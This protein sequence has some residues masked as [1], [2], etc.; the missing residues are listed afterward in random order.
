MLRSLLL[1]LIFIFTACDGAHDVGN[2]QSVD[3]GALTSDQSV[4]PPVNP[5]GPWP[6]SD[7]TTYK[8]DVGL[9]QAIIDASQD[10]AQNIWAV[11]QDTLYLLRPG[12]TR[13]TKFTRTDGLHV[14]GYQNALNQ[15]DTTWITAMA[16]GHANEVFVGYHGFEGIGNPYDDTLEQK[17]LG[18][19]DKVTLNADGTITITRY[20]FRCDYEHSKCW[21]DR[22]PRRMI[23]A[24]TG[25]AAG[26]LFIGFNHGATHVFNDEFGD[27]VHPE[28]TY[29]FPDGS[30]YLKLGEFYGLA[31]TPEGH[32]WM[33]GGYGV[34]LQPFNSAPHFKWVDG[35]M[36]HVFTTY[37]DNHTLDVTAGY[38]EDE[39]GAALSPDGTL[40][41]ASMT[42]GLSSFGPK[43]TNYGAIQHWQSTPGLPTSGLMDVKADPDGTLWLLTIDGQLLRFDPQ[44][45]QVTPW[46]G[47]SSATR[48]HMDDTVTPRALYV[49]MEGGLAVIRAK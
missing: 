10:D 41:L 21:E 27:H 12:Q 34:G 35:R 38:R 14:Q 9:N 49:S 4:D 11:S 1:S 16:G 40:W 17:K 47:V 3:G 43:Q 42:H 45:G 23:F 8:G 5:A 36:I 48:L 7:L 39:R 32:L 26:H 18:Q 6:T 20:E 24:H 19:A 2:V 33:A 22:S 46:P 29:H 13:F 44:S 31:V 25:A 28:V 30:S 37:T 15:S